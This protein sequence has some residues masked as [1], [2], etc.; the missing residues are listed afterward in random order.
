MGTQQV[1]IQIGDGTY[2]ES[3]VLKPY[4]GALAPLVQGNVATPANVVVSGGVGGCFF[5]DGG[6]AWRIEALKGTGAIGLRASNGGIIKFANVDFGTFTGYHIFAEAFSR[7]LA[8]GSYGV[9]GSAQVHAL[10]NGAVQLDGATI[11]FS[12]TPAFS[13]AFAYANLA[14][15]I[16]AVSMTFTNGGTVTG[17]R[18]F[19]GGN[20]AIF[21]NGAGASYLPGNS[22]GSTSTGG[23]YI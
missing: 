9:S 13:L 5:N 16:R 11:T 12:N 10:A 17:S 15:S 4:L 1:T 23:Q 19:A 18:Y 22:A 6:G 20:A 2:S 14:A 8:T 7:I 3:V 21:V